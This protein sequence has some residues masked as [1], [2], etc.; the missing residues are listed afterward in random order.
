M[1]RRLFWYDRLIN[2][3]MRCSTWRGNDLTKLSRQ[4][5]LFGLSEIQTAD[6]CAWYHAQAETV[7][8]LLFIPST[9]YR[10]ESFTIFSPSPLLVL[11]Q[12]QQVQVTLDRSRISTIACSPIT[13]VTGCATIPAFK[14]NVKKICNFSIPCTKFALFVWGLHGLGFYQKSVYKLMS[15]PVYHADSAQILRYEIVY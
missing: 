1:D 9:S 3:F 15:N 4:A 5:Q 6:T 8:L 14:I 7:F 12:P 13:C 11:V 2:P 10:S